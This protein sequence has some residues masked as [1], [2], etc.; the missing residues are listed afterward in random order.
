MKA[1]VLEGVGK[2]RFRDD[3]PVPQIGGTE[4]LIRV[5]ACGLCATDIKMYKGEYTGRL[6]VVA[7]H[8]FTGV[9]ENIGGGVKNIRPGDRVVVDPNESCCAC[10]DCKTARSTFC[11]DMAAYGVFTDGGFAQYAKADERGV[12]KIPDSLPPAAAC[13]VEPVSC[14]VRGIDRAHI[15][16]GDTVAVLGAG[17]MGQLLIQLAAN[18]GAAR[19]VSIDP[20][21]WKLE[22]SKAHGATDTV[23]ASATDTQAKVAEITGGRG[24]DVVFEAVGSVQAFETALALAARGGT[25][26][27]FGFAPEGARAQIVPFEILSKELTIAGS[28][29]NPYTFERAIKALAS[30]IVTTQRLITDRLPLGELEQGIQKAMRRPEGFIKAVVFPDLQE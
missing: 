7:G 29:L 21:G 26:V 5:E 3:Y 30:G 6:P 1:A 20:L 23:D 13:F 28:W 8:E 22:L 11:R 24:A 27:Q 16:A 4:V 18:S 17:T 14:A 15:K 12:Y 10:A 25:V 9:V 2:L 19:V